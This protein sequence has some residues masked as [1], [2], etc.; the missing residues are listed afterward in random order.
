MAAPNKPTSTRWGVWEWKWDGDSAKTGTDPAEPPVVSEAKKLGD[1]ISALQK[2]IDQLKAL[3]GEEH[4]EVIDRR[5][6][7]DA[8]ILR[9]KENQ[10]VMPHEQKL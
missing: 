2:E 9:Q 8:L 1:E 4:T 3:L 5:T 6:K 10:P 7:L